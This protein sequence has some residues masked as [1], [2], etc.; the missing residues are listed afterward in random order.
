MLWWR[1]REREREKF[2]NQPLKII[3]IVYST[4]VNHTLCPLLKPAWPQTTKVQSLHTVT[5][6][7]FL[8]CL[9]HVHTKH[10]NFWRHWRHLVAEAISV[11][12]VNVS[13]KRVLPIR[14]AFAGI[15]NPIIRTYDLCVCVCIMSFLLDHV[16]TCLHID[17]QETSLHHFKG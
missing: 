1:E 10:Y 17:V 16:I 3:T 2:H 4:L 12:P 9:P 8:R 11:R 13:C 5:L 6:I 7:M 14:L 15:N